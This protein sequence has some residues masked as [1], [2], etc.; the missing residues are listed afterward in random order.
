M[1]FPKGRIRD[2]QIKERFPAK[3]IDQ[4]RVNAS[5]LGN[6]LICFDAGEDISFV[7]AGEPHLLPER[8]ERTGNTLCVEGNNTSAYFKQGQTKK[9]LMEVHLP[10][11]TKVDVKFKAGVVILDGGQGGIDIEGTFGEVAGITQ[12]PR[13]QIKLRI[14]DVSL[15]ELQGVAN[16][17]LAVGSAT[18]GWSEMKGRE[19]ITVHC[20]FGG[21]GLFLPPGE[22]VNQEKARFRTKRI[23]TG[24]GSQMTVSTTV[25]SLDVKRW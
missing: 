4:F 21:V 2:A 13:V 11:K 19:R 9:I 5:T 20:R 18:L 3:G 14:G 17:E 23:S 15:N 1:T 22:T 24:S 12:S 7:A 8:V 25:G 6:L 16:I 10:P